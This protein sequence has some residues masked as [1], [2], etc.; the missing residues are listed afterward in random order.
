MGL[1]RSWGDPQIHKHLL[2]DEGEVIVDEVLHH[3]TAYVRPVLE[4]VLGLVVLVGAAFVPMGAAWVLLVAAFVLL[5]RAGWG[6]LREHR[7]RFVITNM[8][9]FRV[10]G[11]LSSNLATMPLSRILDITVVKPLHGRLLGFGHFVF[12]SAAQEQGLR[13]VRYV[14]RP[15][16]RDLAIQRVVQRSG[17]RGP[18]VN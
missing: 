16:E 4:G 18:R 7:D 13:D 2:R 1:L 6:V 5:L 3:W 8:R 17:L 14:G 15:D 11:V 9:V 10:H 12:E